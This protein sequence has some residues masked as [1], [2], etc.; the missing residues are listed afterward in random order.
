M[1]LPGPEFIVVFFL[2]LLVIGF[3]TCDSCFSNVKPFNHYKQN[4]QSKFEG[5]DNLPEVISSPEYVPGSTGSIGP[6]VDKDSAGALSVFGFKGL[7]AAPYGKDAPIDPLYN[8]MG[9]PKCLSQSSGYTDSKGG[10]CLSNDVKKLFLTRGGNQSGAQAQ[11][12]H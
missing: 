5:F 9:D 11:I 12:G 7:Y 10:L 6:S 3:A 8:Q 4:G 1:K 2:F